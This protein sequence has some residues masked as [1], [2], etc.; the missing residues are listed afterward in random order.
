MF[1]RTPLLRSSEARSSH[2]YSLAHASNRS[3]V[4]LVTL[5]CVSR[6]TRSMIARV[7]CPAVPR[8][9]LSRNGIV[10]ERHKRRQMNTEATTSIAPIVHATSPHGSTVAGRSD[11]SPRGRSGSSRIHSRM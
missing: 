10:A 6:I 9:T 1:Y 11:S 3:T 4:L 5:G 7:I 2:A 8:A